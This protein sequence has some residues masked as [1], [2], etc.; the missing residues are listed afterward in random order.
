ML[1]TGVCT[2][3][4]FERTALWTGLW[5]TVRAKVVRRNPLWRLVFLDYES[6]HVLTD[7]TGSG[8]TR[9]RHRSEA[10]RTGSRPAVPKGQPRGLRATPQWLEGRRPGT[11]P[12]MCPGDREATGRTSKRSSR[13]RRAIGDDGDGQHQGPSDSYSEGPWTFSGHGVE[14]GCRRSSCE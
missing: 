3:P 13:R 8:A 12:E 1:C 4:P 7:R 14:S 6:P 10:D 11:E 2:F 5:V 9:T